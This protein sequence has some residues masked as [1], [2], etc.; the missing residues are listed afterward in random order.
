MID[1]LEMLIALAREKHFG[2]A[3]EA[4][5]ITQPSLS[6]GIKQ[7]EA[8]LG[9]QLV[10]RGSRYG[11]LT[12]EGERTLDWARRIVGDS[13]ALRDEMRA[14]HRGLSG[15]LR[16][17]VIPT[18]LTVA[19]DLV[20]RFRAAHSEVR[21]SVLSLSSAEIVEMI[22]NLE[23]D[24]GI[25]YLDNEP[26]GRM[27][28]QPLGREGYCLVCPSDGPL[29]GRAAV[30]WADLAEVPLNL[31]TPDM[32]NRRIVDRHLREAGV[33][34]RVG[35]ESSSTVVLVR[36]VEQGAGCTVLPRRIAGFLAAGRALVSIPIREAGAGPSIG[37]IAP[38]REPH[39]PVL[40]ALLS[41]AATMAEETAR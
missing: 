28:M 7:L 13:R 34:A 26:L 36:L 12:P 5:G 4:I 2:R 16:L 6:A 33:M 10:R 20:Q 1:R 41:V 17:A 9:V 27:A 25:S 24:A 38:W 29:A 18:A 11:G 40:E 32:Q 39:T 30:D 22:G 21:V 3:A 31:L 14:V 37:L 35:V 8:Q 19:A 23:A 15:H